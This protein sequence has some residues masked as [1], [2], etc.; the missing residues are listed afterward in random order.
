MDPT[1]AISAETPAART[2]PRSATLVDV[3]KFDLTAG[4]EDM[5][6]TEMTFRR[7]GVGK[8]TDF[9]GLHLFKD[10]IRL[11]R[12][13]RSLVEETVT[14]VA[15]EDVMIKSGETATFVLK[16]NIRDD[17]E[18]GGESAF[19]LTAIE[20][21]EIEVEGLPVQGELQRIGAVSV[22]T[23][24]LVSGDAIINQVVGSNDVEIANFRLKAEG[25]PTLVE[26]ILVE[27]RG[28]ISRGDVTN[29]TL[30][31]N[32]EEISTSVTVDERDRHVFIIEDG[33]LIDE[34][35]T[36]TFSITAD[37][38][39]RDEDTLYVYI[40][41]T[42][43]ILAIDQNLGFGSIVDLANNREIGRQE[44]EGGA[45]V[46]HAK[47][48]AA[49]NIAIGAEDVVLA[50]VRLL[51]ERDIEIRDIVVTIEDDYTIVENLKIVDVATDRILVS[52]TDDIVSGNNVIPGSIFLT[53]GVERTLDIVVDVKE[54][55]TADQTIRAVVRIG[56]A[57]IRDLELGTKIDDIINPTIT[58][59]RQTIVEIGADAIL[60]GVPRDTTVITGEED[61][62][63]VAFDV[64][65]IG[66]DIEVK[67]ITAQIRVDDNA[68]F[69]SRLTGTDIAAVVT[70]VNLLSGEEIIA[71]ETV[72]DGEVIFTNINKT[73]I[74][75]KEKTFTMEIDLASGLT[76]EYFVAVVI[77]RENIKLVDAINNDPIGLPSPHDYINAPAGEERTVITVETAGTLQVATYA[78]TPET[79]IVPV[80]EYGAEDVKLVIAE[81]DAEREAMIIEEVRVL[82]TPVRNDEAYGVVELLFN[83]AVVAARIM[84]DADHVDFRGLDIEVPL[85]GNH[86]LSAQANIAG[87]GFGIVS[88]DEIGFNIQVMKAT[89]VHSGL[90]GVALETTDGDIDGPVDGTLTGGQAAASA[91][92]GEA[93]ITI[94]N[95]NEPVLASRTLTVA[96]VPV[97]NDT[98][99][100]G[101]CTVTFDSTTPVPDNDCAGNNAA[102][103]DITGTPTNDTVAASLRALVGVDGGA[104]GVLAVTGDTNNA[105]FTA[106]NYADGDITFTDG[107][108]NDITTATPVTGEDAVDDEVVT[109]TIGGLIATAD[110]A[111]AT[112]WTNADFATNLATAI[113]ALPG[114]G[115][116]AVDPANPNVVTITN[117]GTTT[118]TL[119]VTTEG[120]GT[121]AAAAS[122][123]D[124]IPGDVAERPAVKATGDITI[125]G[126]WAVG[127]RIDVSI[128]D[129]S[130]SQYV[131]NAT[132]GTTPDDIA[133]ALLPLIKGL[134]T[135]HTDSSVAGNVITVVSADHTNHAVTV[136]ATGPGA[137][138]AIGN[139]MIVR[140]TV[141]TVSTVKGAT[142]VLADGENHIMT[143]TISADAKDDVTIESLGV[144]LALTGGVTVND[145]IV[146]EGGTVV[147]DPTAAGIAG[148]NT[149]TFTT[150]E[151]IAAGESKTYEIFVFVAG[152]NADGDSIISQLTDNGFAWG[153]GAKENIDSTH[154]DT[155]PSAS[156]TISF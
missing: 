113:N 26:Q 62:P 130:I 71:T 57:D 153:D 63:A 64:L 109:A 28:T 96:A 136:N 144:S 106:V 48:P 133:V 70:S 9:E 66:G 50:G 124:H 149:I 12:T 37:I 17:A 93:T 102:V 148:D 39:G 150:P 117:D 35:D 152:A 98:I 128:G 99:V 68:N 86:K 121:V 36:E 18:V 134:T 10:G 132:D 138:T 95:A 44:L 79:T 53:A 22:A 90:S 89:G 4:T 155:I 34:G 49:G 54:N 31:H 56:D 20:A 151:I 27:V 91:V 24:E 11:T 104:H 85:E 111:G 29:L 32:D 129:Q 118:I 83:N 135:V 25:A 5:P 58:A 6:I 101:A 112:H 145:F 156:F 103:I 3:L 154:V 119:G 1:V 77:E 30:L 92:H 65:A 69:D 141:P 55:A 137:I 87:V 131:V 82:R 14:F 8:S 16:A 127:D 142:T 7:T 78:N 139:P 94:T 72:T 21:G 125:G 123:T 61:I 107:T 116:T 115:A 33:I 84:P 13:P 146:R 45:L 140:Q 46:I 41:E 108:T 80:G 73:I 75:D 147:A 40:S 51:S 126:T 60:L 2:V 52:R 23:V 74:A 100:I 67:Q 122:P 143:V 97:D 81:V 42:A 76:T 114:V 19:K 88:G 110:E 43:D 59:N 105:I 15:L 120:T 47:N 38:Q